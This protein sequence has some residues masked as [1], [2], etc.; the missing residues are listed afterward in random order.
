ME[1]VIERWAKDLIDRYRLAV[2]FRVQTFLATLQDG[3]TSS[4][5]LAVQGLCAKLQSLIAHHW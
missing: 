2:N 1:S 3:P 4:M 5:E